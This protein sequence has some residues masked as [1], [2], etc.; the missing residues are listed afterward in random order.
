MSNE[1]ISTD[2]AQTPTATPGAYIALILGVLTIGF[3]PIFVKLADTTGDVVGFYRLA[4]G[5]SAITLPMAIRWRQGKVRL[6]RRG[7]WLAVVAGLAFATDIGVW[8]QS[9]RYTTASNATFLGNTAPIWVGLGAW[10]LLK[11]K[12]RPL[13]WLGLIVALGGAVLLVG[14]DGFKGSEAAIG[15]LMALSVGG[16]Y[17]A[18]QLAA[19]QARQFVDNL[20]FMWIFSLTGAIALGTA[21]LLLG[22][23]FGGLSTGNVLA[24]LALGLVTHVGGWLLINN[25]YSMLPAS[26]VTVILLGQ[27]IVATLFA[28]PILGEVPTWLHVL[29]G[30]ITI[31]GIYIVLRSRQAD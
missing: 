6:P 27:P 10:W 20:T 3:A 4:I 23:S 5:T 1:P 8:N 12:L 22:S 18:Y 2:N 16:A 26:V 17:A 30:L 9:L 24:L 28:A 13:Y 7:L 31:G 25:T 11:E 14:L 19:S 21:A 15:N 29:G